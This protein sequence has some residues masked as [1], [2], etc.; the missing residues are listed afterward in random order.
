M[1][2]HIIIYNELLTTEILNVKY[3]EQQMHT[4]LRI[5]SFKLVKKNVMLLAH[6]WKPWKNCSTAELNAVLKYIDW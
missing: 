1:I 5:L 6:F 2:Y 4:S 3:S